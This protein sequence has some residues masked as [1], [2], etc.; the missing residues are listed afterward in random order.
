MVLTSN[1]SMKWERESWTV[2][3]KMLACLSPPKGRIQQPSPAPLGPVFS[4]D[5]GRVG[6]KGRFGV[7]GSVKAVDHC[8]VAMENLGAGRTWTRSSDA[9][10][11]LKNLLHLPLGL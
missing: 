1:I 3:E 9:Q 4:R 5:T 7:A 2:T 8:F 10:P 11:G 6:G